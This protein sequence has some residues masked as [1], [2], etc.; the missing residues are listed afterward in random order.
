M[1]IDSFIQAL[2][3]FGHPEIWWSMLLGVMMGLIFGVIP[4]LTGI[5][6]MSI[7]L[8]FVFLLTPD[9][10]LPLFVAILPSKL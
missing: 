9:Q 6:A 7:L 2:S 1:V 10:A 8:P 5:I 3:N 4:G